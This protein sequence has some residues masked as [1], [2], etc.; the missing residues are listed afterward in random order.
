MADYDVAVVGAGV[1]G[2]SAAYHLARRGRSTIV[3]E[4]DHP[5][6]GP[7]TGRSS[8]ICRAFYT[9]EFLA[10]V[11]SDSI[12]VLG[13]FVATVGGASGFHRTGALF[14]HGTA[15]AAEVKATTAALKADGIELDLLA[16]MD[17]ALDH[18]A[19]SRDGV[20]VAVWE[21]G[22]GYADPVLTTTSYLDAARGLGAVVRV[23]TAVESI[24]PGAPVVLR[25]S[26]D[27]ITADRVLLAA[28][29]WT[30]P[31]TDSFGVHLPTH[32]ERHV[33]ASLRCGDAGP[34]HVVADTVVGWYGKPDLGGLYLVGGLT[35]GAAIDPD[36]FT[37]RVSEEELLEYAALLVRRFPALDISTIAGGWAGIYDVSPDWQPVIGEVAPNVV[38]DCGSSGHGFKLAPVLGSYVASLVAGDDVDVL[39]P[40]HPD[41]F[42]RGNS[43]SAG[44]GEA[45]VLG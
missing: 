1:H 36:D 21:P 7:T 19:V 17:L 45:H 29:P 35:A 18:P 20:A 25:T 15:E 26:G 39:R 38:I 22:A 28:G 11:A 31:L 34:T 16:A 3:L 8:A 27:E 37:E 10:R 44:F 33:V 30:N 14:L 13:N 40:F 24:E 42:V 12:R 4:R 23:K 6:N 5:A 32:A 43:L 9:N 41:R 2:A